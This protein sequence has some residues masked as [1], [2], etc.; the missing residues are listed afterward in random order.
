MVK[1][2]HFLPLMVKD[3]LTP[4]NLVGVPGLWLYWLSLQSLF[5]IPTGASN[6]SDFW[7]FAIAAKF[8]ISCGKLL[9]FFRPY[10][11]RQGLAG[12]FGGR[13]MSVGLLVT[14]QE[15]FFGSDWSLK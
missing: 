1:I 4:V 5:F 9:P 10:G 12:S 6:K 3:N 14:S 11:H 8:M 7:S 13:H 15:L 2:Y